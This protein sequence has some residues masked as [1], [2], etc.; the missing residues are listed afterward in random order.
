VGDLV[1]G[2]HGLAPRRS[3]VAAIPTFVLE[4]DQ[5]VFRSVFEREF[6]P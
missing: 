3:A 5:L 6:Q 1:G 4:R 2:H